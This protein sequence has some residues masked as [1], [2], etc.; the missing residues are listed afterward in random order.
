M[1]LTE[2]DASERKPLRGTSH[3]RHFFWVIIRPK[4]FG[5]NVSAVKLQARMHV[6]AVQTANVARSHKMGS[7]TVLGLA[8]GLSCS[9]FLLSPSGKT[10]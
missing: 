4:R 7:I 8:C 5:M 6:R 2:P 3:W 10:C 9:N 1:H